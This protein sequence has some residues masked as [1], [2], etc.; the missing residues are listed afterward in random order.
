[1]PCLKSTTRFIKRFSKIKCCSQTQTHAFLS[2]YSS[3]LRI[4]SHFITSMILC[5]ARFLCN[6]Y[7][8][9]CVHATPGYT[10]TNL[11]S[12]C[13]SRHRNSYEHNLCLDMLKDGF[14]QSFC[15]LFNL[16]QEQKQE[17]D[18]LGADSGLADRLL[19]EEEPEKLDQLKHHL[20]SAEAA[21]RRGEVTCRWRQIHGLVQ[22]K[23]PRNLQSREFQLVSIA[24]CSSR[25]VYSPEQTLVWGLGDHYPLWMV[26]YLEDRPNGQ[27][28]AG[29]VLVSGRVPTHSSLRATVNLSAKA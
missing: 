17:R 7:A 3:M 27:P 24:M 2:K 18:R 1:M 29:S 23:K 21:R 25:S 19:L 13:F 10:V 14:H 11:A 20:T 4:E 16:M 28:L 22:S 15:E 6:I 5:T 9:I 8:E 26:I 12:H